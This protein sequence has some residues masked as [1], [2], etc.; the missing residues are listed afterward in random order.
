MEYHRRLRLVLLELVDPI[1]GLRGVDHL[2]VG[3]V[4]YP[5]PPELNHHPQAVVVG[6]CLQAHHQACLLLGHH[7]QIGNLPRQV[8]V[9]N[10]AFYLI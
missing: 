6:I 3:M 5:H 4:Q 1:S 2:L 7:R 9:V 8:A 10:L